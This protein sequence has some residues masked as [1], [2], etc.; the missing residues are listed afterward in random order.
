MKLSTIGALLLLLLS[1]I[2]KIFAQ[3]STQDIKVMFEQLEILKTRVEAQEEE[4]KYLKLKLAKEEVEK[5]AHSEK[6]GL[7]LPFDGGEVNEKQ[8]EFVQAEIKEDVVEAINR[9]MDS[10]EAKK[11][12]ES[13]STA[14]VKAGYGDKGFYLESLDGK[15]HLHMSGR[16]QVLYTYNDREEDKNVV[17]SP[18]SPGDRD[19]SSFRLRRGRLVWQGYAFTKELQYYFQLETPGLT[20]GTHLLDYYVDYSGLPEIGKYIAIK[21]GQFK[22]PFSRQFMSS[23]STLQLVDRSI[24]NAEF[25]LDRDVGVDFH[26]ELFDRKLEYHLGIFTGQGINRRNENSD[27][28]MLY[29]GRLAWHPLGFFDYKETDIDYSET[30]KATI[31]FGAAYNSGGEI[32]TGSTR[33]AVSDDIYMTTFTADGGLKYKGFSLLTE[34]F[35]RNL[36]EPGFASTTNAIGYMVQGGYFILP[37]RLELASRYAWM[38]REFNRDKEDIGILVGEGNN[39]RTPGSEE[40]ITFGLNYYFK[41]HKNK[42]QADVSRLNQG[43]LPVSKDNKPP[44][45]VNDDKETW[46]FRLQY[47]LAF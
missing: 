28:K 12:I 3:E 43:F 29:M 31:G 6:P 16:V 26:R 15:F 40:E 19:T 27:N 36:R 7:N 9:Y 25:S 22:V 44:F 18:T 30:L 24:L 10:P 13:L 2:N 37:K 47:Q 4:I 17:S 11:K 46:R 1:P 41:G 8:G 14:K 38:D 45:N 39:N 32:R 23:S 21:G 42:I 20:E 35:L 34:A 33:T 5:V